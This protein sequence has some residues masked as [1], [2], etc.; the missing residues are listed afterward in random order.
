M[1]VSFI[2]DKVLPG[3]HAGRELYQILV[4]VITRATYHLVYGDINA[5]ASMLTLQFGAA[6]KMG[7]QYIANLGQIKSLIPFSLEWREWYNIPI[8]DAPVK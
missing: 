4:Y 8:W 6:T 5:E 2:T 3:R 1:S 7:F